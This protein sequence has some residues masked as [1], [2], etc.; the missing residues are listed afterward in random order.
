M[1]KIV[2][3][4]IL[5]AATAL[6]LFSLSCEKNVDAQPPEE[7]I[8]E[9]DTL[10]F[11]DTLSLRRV[12]PKGTSRIF[13]NGKEINDS[14]YAKRFIYDAIVFHD[15]KYAPARKLQ[16]LSADS[17]RYMFTPDLFTP[18]Y[19]TYGIHNVKDGY[20][21]R[22]PYKIQEDYLQKDSGLIYYYHD[23]ASGQYRY[24]HRASGN[25]KEL[26]ISAFVMKYSR[27]KTVT[28]GGE[29]VVKHYYTR[30][31]TQ[32]SAFKE[33]FIQTLGPL[34]TLAIQEYDVTYVK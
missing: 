16:I 7:I 28:E 14:M 15:E 19:I 12:W 5:I 2:H 32:N 6:W 25:N 1:K 29:Q 24:V 20:E 33:S 10:S 22:A 11:P 26:K 4:P 21:F 8:V 31:T 9:E 30:M 13:A 18:E 17:V 34:D 27:Y 3:L 23:A